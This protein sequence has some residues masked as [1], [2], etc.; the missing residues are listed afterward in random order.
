VRTTR[1]GDTETRVRIKFSSLRARV[2]VRGQTEQANEL[3]GLIL[4]PKPPADREADERLYEQ[5]YREADEKEDGAGQ[6]SQPAEVKSGL[7]TMKTSNEEQGREKTTAPVVHARHTTSF[8]SPFDGEGL[9]QSNLVNYN[10]ITTEKW[11]IGRREESEKWKM[12]AHRRSNE[13]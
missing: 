6:S 4:A 1:R 8:C 3:F 11:L 10:Q 13:N 12:Q 9:N 5:R 7:P 2:G